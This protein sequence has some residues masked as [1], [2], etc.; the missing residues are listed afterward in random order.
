MRKTRKKKRNI[1]RNNIKMAEK[2]LK[3]EKKTKI[4]KQ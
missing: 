3:N 2:K 1:E 4:D